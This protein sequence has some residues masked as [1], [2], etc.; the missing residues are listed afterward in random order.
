MQDT[1]STVASPVKQS[2]NLHGEEITFVGN[3]LPRQCGIATFTTDLWNAVYQCYAGTV[4]MTVIAMNNRPEGYDYPDAVEWTINQSARQDYERAAEFVNRKNSKLIC[5][6]HEFGIFG[7][8]DGNFILDFMSNV[9]V[10]I[11]VTLH[12]VLEKPSSGQRDVITMM[13][14]IVSRFVVMSL[15]AKT[16]LHKNYEIPKQNMI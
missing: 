11:V 4:R 13:N 5:I 3:H 2:A 8:E 1:T 6:Q 14:P 12:T 7:G 15:R 9:E 16:F 10:P